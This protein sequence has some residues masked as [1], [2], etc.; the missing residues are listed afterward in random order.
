MGNTDWQIN[1]SALGDCEACVICEL[2]E[3]LDR[4]FTAVDRGYGTAADMDRWEAN[5]AIVS[6]N[7]V[8]LEN[9]PDCELWRKVAAE[10]RADQEVFGSSQRRSASQDQQ[11][12]GLDSQDLQSHRLDSRVD[13]QDLQS[14]SLESHRLDSQDP[15][16]HRLDSQDPQSHRL[17]SQ[18][19]QCQSRW[20]VQELLDTCAELGLQGR[21][22]RP[23]VPVLDLT[24]EYCPLT[25]NSGQPVCGVQ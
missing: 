23:N 22:Q 12:Q 18:D 24:P 17:D 9:P 20:T 4:L 10:T 2:Y 1:M 8:L 21:A 13:S 5:F 3:E 19:P 6:A 15:Q 25:S 14:Y 7:Q 16:S 11:Y